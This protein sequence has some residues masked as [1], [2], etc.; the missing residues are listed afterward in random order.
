MIDW[1]KIVNL[2]DFL[3]LGLVSRVYSI[4]FTFGAADVMICQGGSTN[5][6]FDDVFLTLNLNGQN[7]YI[8]DNHLG[9][10]DD[11]SD[12]WLGVYV[13]AD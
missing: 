6:F 11:N 9:Y 12:I 13:N 3:A 4:N 7:P 8:F 10:V 2:N 1:Y 5:I